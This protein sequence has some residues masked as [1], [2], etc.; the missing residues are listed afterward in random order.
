MN[1]F[2]KIALFLVLA[3]GAITSF[4]QSEQDKRLALNYY[5]QGEFDK[6]LTYYQRI[7]TANPSFYNF[8][9]TYNC[10]VELKEL[11]E[12]EKLTKKYQRKNPK[13]LRT[14]VYLGKVYDLAED[15]EKAKAYYDKAINNIDQHTRSNKIGTL[16]LL[17]EKENKLQ[18]AVETYLK[19]NQFAKGNPYMYNRKIAQLYNRQGKTELMIETLL[20]L[21]DVNEGFLLQT[22][23]GLNNSI[24]FN[25]EPKKVE[26]LKKELLKRVQAHPNQPVY[27]ELL[28]WFF[29]QKG[30]FKSALIQLKALDKR[31][32]GEGERVYN[33][34][35]TCF[36]NEEYDI[37]IE[38]Y[39]YIIELSSDSRY[40]RAAKSNRLKTLKKKIT[41]GRSYTQE[42]VLA[43]KKD[44]ENTLKDLGKNSYSIQLIK[45]LANLNA[46]YINDAQ[47][48][49]DLLED[50]LKFPRL[51]SKEKAK[52]KIQL[53]DV[54]VVQNEVWDA[55]LY[56]MQVEKNFKEDPIGHEAKYKN[57]KIYYYT[58]DFDWAKA[59]LDVLK[60]S[61]SKLI[62]N[63][64]MELS[65]LI[66]SNTGL[67]TTE[68]PM[69][70]FS[71]ADL[72]IEQHLYEQAL[73][74]YDTLNKMFPYHSLED[75][76]LWKKHTIERKK[77]N[78]NAAIG[79]LEQIATNFNE[80]VLAD[81][82]L[83]ELGIIHETL[84]K[85]QSKAAEYY[86][87]LLFQY[88]GSLFLIEA[89]KRYRAITN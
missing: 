86:K 23:S 72:L 20:N 54:L 39:D 85:D 78:I 64:A 83:Y 29:T 40:Y 46:Y 62:A 2:F 63:D 71:S 3:V 10:H 44:Y 18:Y 16:A 74:K 76:I 41:S 14:Y 57:A 87:K 26:L 37:A 53:A 67:D 52:V 82:A 21:V 28:A 77:G 45:E 33:L 81:N 70:L 38:A 65:L 43:L 80:D 56:Y 75:E 35:N 12:A 79:Y 58:G 66:T 51:N 60:A 36:N 24:D 42:E 8:S 27:N 49:R 89:R 69:Q 68:K 25:E 5:N 11:K 7:Y 17:F 31:E 1:Y 48:A 88:P 32:Q 19:A 9:Y 50:A 4:S 22:Q 15:A 13:E 6:A 34:G 30:D 47:A 61:T 73:A 59:Q 84:L 55:S